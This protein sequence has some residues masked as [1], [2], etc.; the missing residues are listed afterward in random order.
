MKAPH[1]K[2]TFF[3]GL[4]TSFLLVI[5][6]CSCNR[7]QVASSSN[8]EKVSTDESQIL[9]VMIESV[10]DSITGNP[11]MKILQQQLVKGELTG[12]ADTEST[13]G[14]WQISLLNAKGK[15]ID[16]LIM[17]DPHIQDVEIPN[18]KGDF[19]I[20]KIQYIRTEIPVRFNYSSSVKE[21]EVIELTADGKH[22][23]FF[24]APLAL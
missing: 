18:D 14:Q 24:R 8:K 1:Y 10:I 7:K 20:Q 12:I 13:P 15:R 11:N 2:Y 16:S 6:T 21:V 19:T 5:M 9:Y 4:I 22:K 23:T 17:D 3:L